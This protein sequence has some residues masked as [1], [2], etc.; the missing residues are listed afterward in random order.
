MDAVITVTSTRYEGTQQS[1]NYARS[2][3]LEKKSCS[4]KCRK[5][6]GYQHLQIFGIRPA[7]TFLFLILT[8]LAIS[9]AF[10]IGPVS[11]AAASKERDSE[12]IHDILLPQ[13]IEEVTSSYQF[14]SERSLLLEAEGHK[15]EDDDD[16][17]IPPP[18]NLRPVSK[19]RSQ[20][21]T[22]FKVTITSHLLPS[23]EASSPLRHVL[24]A[25]EDVDVHSD[26]FLV[27]V[28]QTTF[29]TDKVYRL[30]KGRSY[31]VEIQTEFHTRLSDP[32]SAN[33]TIRPNP[34]DRFVV[35]Y[36]NETCF[37]VLWQPPTD[38]VFQRY[39]AKLSPPQSPIS[40]LYVT[41]WEYQF[42]G[43][44]PGFFALTPGK[45][46]NIS[47]STISDDP[48]AGT[49]VES[50]AV[51]KEYRTMPLPVKNVTISLVSFGVGGGTGQKVLVEWDP[52]SS[53]DG[54]HDGFNVYIQKENSW[55]KPVQKFVPRSKPPRT[56]LDNTGLLLG[57]EYSVV[58]KTVSG[59]VSSLPVSARFTYFIPPQ[60]NDDD[61]T[62]IDETKEEQLTLGGQREEEIGP[63]LD[64]EPV[65]ILEK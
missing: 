59:K 12:E 26:S 25:G 24:H 29:T 62:N 44:R 45:S 5:L 9:A 65:M 35:W 21:L 51:F 20:K 46:Y 33:F 58:V 19:R 30:E 64:D 39:K 1:Q 15:Y 36:R 50:I 61:D 60:K 48:V 63:I 7:S 47:V 41:R 40:T 55:G 37:L 27:D 38:G 31:E 53:L 49:E 6:G 2:L 32:I 57:E 13:D 11:A 18:Q 42:G 34:P 3:L 8:I 28:D 17:K 23:E 16:D 56:H 4:R 22:G 52:P 10:N 43:V 14:S 54:E